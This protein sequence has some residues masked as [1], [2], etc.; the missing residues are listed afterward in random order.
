MGNWISRVLFGRRR[1]QDIE[2]FVEV[3]EEE[4]EASPSVSQDPVRVEIRQDPVEN[5]QPPP[6]QPAPVENAQR[7]ANNPRPV[8]DRSIFIQRN[9][10]NETI[11]RTPGQINGNQ[12]VASELN[13]C[14][15]TV[16]DYCDSMT[17]DKC[18]N[19]DF[20]L[21]AVR[22]AIFVRECTNCKFIMVCGQFRCRDCMNCDFFMH[23]KTGPVVESSTNLRIGCAEIA[24]PE[25]YAHMERA[26]IPVCNNIWTDV[27][28]FTP[29]DGHFAY[30]DDAHLNLPHFPVNESM[31]PFIHRRDRNYL[32]FPIT[33][34]RQHIQK[35][36]EVSKKARI[37]N[38]VEQEGIPNIAFSIECESSEAIPSLFGRV[39]YV[40]SNE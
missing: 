6:P 4:R 34:D 39:P 32:T 18:Q 15:V 8:I 40:L 31:L 3:P 28:D 26:K 7:P 5:A 21:S 38:I 35:I 36:I 24:Y 13:G 9:K 37:V 19:T 30:L 27:H 17:F 1:D 22:G 25:L 14:K 23:V 20:V 16:L 11:V 33:I 12:F 10:S 29:G 2:I